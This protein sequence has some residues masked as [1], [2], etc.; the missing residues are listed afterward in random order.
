MSGQ[1]ALL[2][3]A[4]AIG[5]LVKQG[6]HPKRSIVYA[7][8][9]GEEPMILGSTEWAETHAAELKKKAVLYIKLRLEREG[10]LGAAG[11]HDFQHLVNEVA[12]AV[13]DPETGVFHRS[14]GRA[15]K[16]ALMRARRRQRAYQSRGEAG[17]RSGQRDFPIDALGSGS[18]FST[19]IDHLGCAGAGCGVCRRG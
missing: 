2:A 10:F 11:S 1:V 3:E 9:D 15:R 8:W 5:G 18:D 19:F 12:A 17:R 6:W 16:F 4:K 14:A 7:S 13:I